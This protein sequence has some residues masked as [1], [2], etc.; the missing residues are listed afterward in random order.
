MTDQPDPSASLT[1]YEVIAIVGVNASVRFDNP[2]YSGAFIVPRQRPVVDMET[3][4]PTGETETVEV[5]ED[6]NPHLTKCVIVPL[7]PSGAVDHAAFIERLTD[8]ARGVRA[9]MD[10]V[11]AQQITGDLG[12]LVGLTTPSA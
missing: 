11:H 8:Q 3:G 2:Y 5:D 12:D 6:P 4:Q 10:A 9:R 7:L 1:T